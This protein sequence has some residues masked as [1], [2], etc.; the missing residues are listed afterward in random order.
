MKA[1]NECRK[2]VRHLATAPA[3]MMS[4]DVRQTLRAMAN[5]AAFSA[6]DF[7]LLVEYVQ[8]KPEKVDQRHILPM[9]KLSLMTLEYADELEDS[10]GPHG[11]V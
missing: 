9:L 7:R 6:T 11:R 5:D 1:E 2:L 3:D 8:D 10:H 4:E